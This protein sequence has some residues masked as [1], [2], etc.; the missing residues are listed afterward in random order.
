MGFCYDGPSRLA[1]Q[2]TSGKKASAHLRN[3]GEERNGSS[4]QSSWRGSLVAGSGKGWFVQGGGGRGAT[5]A[6]ARSPAGLGRLTC[7]VSLSEQMPPHSKNSFG[8]RGC[9][10]L[11]AIPPG[12]R[13][14]WWELNKWNGAHHGPQETYLD[15]GH[16]I[17]DARQSELKTENM[18]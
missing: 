6:S 14:V 3:G 11:C 1:H 4:G 9:I 5:R 8:G 2:I 18:G 17:S 13:T 16:H 10:R 12:L 15:V 7:R